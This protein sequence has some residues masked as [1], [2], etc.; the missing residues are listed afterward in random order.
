M[1][2]FSAHSG[3][4]HLLSAALP[5][6]WCCF[7]AVIGRNWSNVLA[8]AQDLRRRSASASVRNMPGAL[9]VCSPRRRLKLLLGRRHIIRRRPMACCFTLGPILVLIPVILSWL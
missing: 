8:G 3:H 2:G 6:C 1:E 9:G 5:C 4:A 7:A